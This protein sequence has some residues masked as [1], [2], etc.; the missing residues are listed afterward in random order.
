MKRSVFGF[1]GRYIQGPGALDAL[2]ALLADLGVARP[3]V[4]V[5]PFLAETLGRRLLD[6]LARAGLAAELAVFGGEC[7]KAEIER[8]GA[9]LLAG[10]VDGI[11]VA[12]GGKAIDTAKG[13]AKAGGLRLVVA[14]T[15]ASNDSPTSRLIVLYDENHR[16]LGV[17]RLARNPDAV[18]VDTALI[19]AAPVRFFRAGIGDALSKAFEVRACVEAGGSNFFDG[20]SPRTA[21]LLA[22]ACLDTL[23]AHGEAA[24]AAVL[25]GA[26]DEAVEAVVE[27][28]V[29]M[30][31]LAFESG[32]LSI[33]HAL[34]RGFSAEPAYRHALHGE[35]VGF[36][37]VVQL[38]ADPA[39][40]GRAVE[41]ARFAR[42][43]GLPVTL[44]D[45][46][47]DAGDADAL[48]RIGVLT[49]AAPYI[50]N[51]PVRLDPSAAA[52]AIRAADAIGRALAG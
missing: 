6:D 29:L 24:V 49:C 16:I 2:P 1:P 43:L 18:V 38:V 26:P 3:G 10:G 27:A 47:G 14:P 34:T 46:G 32:G 45:L 31:G 19:A 40:A 12:G 50:G 22:E 35:V 13:V 41:I 48:L 42:G 9:R 37:T 21:L 44:A 7:T 11:V 15:I 51:F 36:G 30:S 33:A 25:R 28:T 8:V 4:V 39:T 17:D 5:D 23:R 20:R 52:D